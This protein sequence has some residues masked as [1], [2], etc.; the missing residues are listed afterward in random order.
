MRRINH[1][2]VALF[3]APAMLFTDAAQ[4]MQIQQ[5]DRMAG[6]DQDEYIAELIQGAEKVLTDEGRGDQSAQVRTLFATNLTGD[7]ASL[8]MTEFYRNL[9]IGR[10]ADAKRAA[11]DPNARRIE[12]EDAMALTL[13]KNGIPHCRLPFSPLSAIL[14]PG[15]RRSNNRKPSV[16]RLFLF[17]M[18]CVAMPLCGDS[19]LTGFRIVR[20]AGE[21]LWTGPNAGQPDTHSGPARYV[22][23]GFIPPELSAPIEAPSSNSL[24]AGR[25]ASLRRRFATTDIAGHAR[26]AYPE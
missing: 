18:V 22:E 23:R 10:V 16:E 24:N 2:P 8:G 21:Y 19:L 20:A 6:A 4:A 7:E 1:F 25:S 11:G 9:A 15:S 26:R 3:L 12:V 5:F 13:K 17:L 14:S